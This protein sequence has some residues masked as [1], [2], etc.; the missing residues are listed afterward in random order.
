M[1]KIF[2]LYLF[3]EVI[4]K[5]NDILILNAIKNSYKEELQRY[6]TIK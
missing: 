6:L 5:T 4:Y 3:G 2:K 1:K